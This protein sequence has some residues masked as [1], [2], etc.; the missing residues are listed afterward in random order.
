[1]KHP[2]RRHLA[3][4][5]L[6]LAAAAAPAASFAHHSFAAEFDVQK[7]VAVEGLV[8]KAQFVN[9]HSWIYLDVRNADGS[10]TNWG[11]E[12]GSPGILQARH[13]T[14]ADV[15]AG[16]RVR[17][18]GFRSRNTGPFGYAQT[19]VLGDG[20]NIPIG[21]APDAPPVRQAR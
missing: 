6:C 9:P 3:I 14:K 11:F 15:R 13:I 2:K 7:P 18:T 4:A 1:M 17:I 8:T 20:R 16:S 19:V 5:G 10:T 21:S 12:F